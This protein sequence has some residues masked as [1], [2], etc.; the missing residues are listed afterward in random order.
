ML[1]LFAYRFQASLWFFVA[2][3]DVLNVLVTITVI[4]GV[5]SGIAGWSYAQMLA[6]AGFSS[7]AFG[8]LFFLMNPF[9]LIMAMRNGS[10]D[11]LFTKPYNKIVMVFSKYGSFNLISLIFGGIALLVYG[12]M[13]TQFSI[14][15]LIASIFLFLLGTTAM[16]MFILFISLLS[17][18]LFKS[19]SYINWLTG[20]IQNASQYPLFI[21]G[22][23]FMVL[24]TV[25]APIA[26]A[27]FYPAELIFM[28]VS[29]TTVAEVAAATI[30]MAYLFY[31]GSMYLFRFYTSGGG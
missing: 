31:K 24:L 6:L 12:I 9:N 4:Y 27:T 17:Y 25:A 11:Q 22:S 20:I 28:K 21:Y 14:L 1:S 13:N 7:T 18:V 10:A 23:V 19:G 26:I 2:L 8:I 5:S 16:L 3:M 15:P 30:V 29:I